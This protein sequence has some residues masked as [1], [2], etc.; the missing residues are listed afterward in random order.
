MSALLIIGV[1]VSAS[2]SRADDQKPTH[3]P[4]SIRTSVTDIVVVGAPSPI[5]QEITGTYEDDTPGL[6]GGI[7]GGAAAATPSTQAGPVTVNFPFPILQLPGAIVGGIS[8]SAKRQMQELRDAMAEDIAAANSRTLINEGLA[9]DVY[10]GLQRLPEL[11]SK[12]FAASTEIPDGTDAVL[13]VSVKEI[14]ID[15]QKK[16]AILTAAASLSLESVALGS[17]LYNREVRYQDRASL[18]EWTENDN[19]LW[20]DFANY[21]RHYL[22]REIT[23]DSFARIELN[24]ELRPAKSDDIKTGRKNVWQGKTEAAT[25]TLAW[26]FELLENSNYG[27]FTDAITADDIVFDLEIYD[28]NRMVYEMKQLSE[29]R[30]TLA[31]ELDPCQT[32]R[33]SVRPTYYIGDDVRIGE[34]MQSASA[35]PAETG[36][37]I[38][39][40]DATESPGYTQDFAAL[41]F[42]CR[43]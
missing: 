28:S 12:L 27:A 15:V 5:D 7:S 16:D 10:R 17:K 42:E 38:V 24:H 19:A 35:E 9:L 3:M 11:D 43:R 4:E 25:P 26:E 31:Y 2:I 22:G 37:G 6:L 1:A 36:A 8:G 34:W 20:Q 41:K 18:E 32:Y 14:T 13:Y 39:G 40:R 23:A 33:W 30:H 29:A 21:A